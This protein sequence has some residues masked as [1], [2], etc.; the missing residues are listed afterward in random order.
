[1]GVYPGDTCS[2][3][4]LQLRLT[5]Y[6]WIG[7]KLLVISYLIFR[8]IGRGGGRP[9]SSTC[10]DDHCS[11][12]KFK[13]NKLKALKKKI[14]KGEKNLNRQTRQCVCLTGEVW[15]WAPTRC[16]RKTL[17]RSLASLL[18]C[19]GWLYCLSCGDINLFS[20]TLLGPAFFLRAKPKPLLWATNFSSVDWTLVKVKKMIYLGKVWS[21]KGLEINSGRR[22][23]VDVR[24]TTVC[25]WVA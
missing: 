6:V 13:F 10:S 17:T 22:S 11:R 8:A 24:N 1:M 14:K 4:N 18:E 12:S 25:G 23:V 3:V 21:W 2:S 19:V 16:N 9:F 15:R 20:H 5:N 7:R